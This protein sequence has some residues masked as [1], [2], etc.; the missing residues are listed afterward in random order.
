M[1]PPG[2]RPPAPAGANLDLLRDHNA[3]LV[4][5][6]VRR[7]EGV[8]RVE[9]A[10]RTG[11]TAQAISK[12]VAR[13]AR[14]GL[15]RQATVRAGV[16]GKPR[17]GLHL[18]GGARHALGV[19]VDRGVLRVALLDLRGTVVDRAREDLPARVPPPQLVRRITR[20]CR[21]LL[22]R[23]GVANRSVLGLGVGFVGP[24]DH[25]DGVIHD[26]NHMPGWHDIPLRSMVERATGLPTLVDKDTSVAVLAERWLRGGALRDAALLYIGSG[27]GAGFLLGE[28]VHRGSRTNAGEF[29]HTIVKP[30]GPLCA[31]GRRGCLE[32]FCSP[33]AVVERVRRRRRGRPGAGSPPSWNAALALEFASI[34]A[35]ASQGE[36]VARAELTCAARLLGAAIVDLVQLLDLEH[37]VFAGPAVASAG[38]VYIAEA[39]RA[40]ETQLQRPDWLR[41]TLSTST[42]EEDLIPFG[43]A[44]LVLSTS[45]GA[46]RRLPLGD[47]P[48]AMPRR[49]ARPLL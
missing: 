13:L 27:I 34:C 8:S 17:M 49:A 25:R 46:A 9:V 19:Q 10:L 26:A 14:E 38:R 36:P 29:G 45:L 6:L 1:N 37:V 33:A 2:H 3:S 16:V 32:V 7:E 35:Q 18:V 40:L 30:F 4:L 22:A 44:L 23:A 39:Q 42:L 20:T 31:C 28:E 12:I 24:L 48:V 47:L 21:A 11:L 5:D 15:V 43:A 41:V